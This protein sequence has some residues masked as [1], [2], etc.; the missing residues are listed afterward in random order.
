LNNTNYIPNQFVFVWDD[1]FFPYPAYLAVKSVAVQCEPDRIILLKTPRLD[2]VENFERLRREVACLDPLNIDLQGWLEDAR[3][4]CVNELLEAN[5]F[6]KA[7]GYHG[8]VSDL[9]RSLVLYRE[10]GI[11]LDT[12]T[13]TLRDLAPLRARGGFVAEEHI[14]VSSEVYRRDSPWRYLRTA[15]LTAARYLCSRLPFGVRC[16]QAIAPLFVRA[17][18]NAVMGFRKGHPLPWDILIRIAQNYPRRPERYPLLGPDAVQDLVEENRY[19][20]VTIYPPRYFS[21]LGPTMTFQYFHRWGRRH[22]DAMCRRVLHPD[23][24]VVHWS[25]NATIARAIPR[26][27]ADLQRLAGEQL[28]SRLAMQAAFGPRVD[29]ATHAARGIVPA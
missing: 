11:Y 20:D 23:T 3:L 26:S 22:I 14:L 4:P 17:L 5:R 25:N 24:C 27:D 18:H 7:R 29:W 2:G 9:L 6:L 21:P 19:P 1:V 10:G 15:P 12:D 16:F 13:L 28:F 8:S